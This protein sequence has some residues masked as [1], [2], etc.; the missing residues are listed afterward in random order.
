[1]LQSNSEEIERI[2]FV[3]HH[4]WIKAQ[5]E[6]R[7]SCCGLVAMSYHE[8][9]VNSDV[10][11]LKFDTY[12]TDNIL[13]Y[14]VKSLKDKLGLTDAPVAFFSSF[15]FT[16]LCRHGHED[17]ALKNKYSYKEDA[18]W[19]RKTLRTRSIDKMKTIVFFRNLMLFHWICYA[20]FLDLRII[21]AFDSYG[22]NHPSDLKALYC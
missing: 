9:F 3:Q 13:N 16:K 6:T 20:I 18:G 22:G 14:V 8:S 2:S 5:A 21:Q 1:L 7:P 15:F 17:P 12:V 11:T 10:F 4:Q 19:T